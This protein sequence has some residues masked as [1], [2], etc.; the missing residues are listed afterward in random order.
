MIILHITQKGKIGISYLTNIATK[1]NQCGKRFKLHV[2]SIQK[3]KKKG[4]KFGKDALFNVH[5]KHHQ[6]NISVSSVCFFILYLSNILETCSQNISSK[7][8]HTFNQNV[9]GSAKELYH[10]STIKNII[11]ISTIL[12]HIFLDIDFYILYTT[13]RYYVCPHDLAE[14]Y[15]R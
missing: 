13:I 12:W 8:D 7:K 11:S 14:K 2:D 4:N 9:L 15:K 6:Q 3:Q 5:Q 10:M 1:N